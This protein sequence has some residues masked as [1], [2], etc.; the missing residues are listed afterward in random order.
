[1]S[2]GRVE[3]CVFYNLLYNDKQIS[4]KAY[5]VPYGIIYTMV[6]PWRTNCGFK[7]G[8]AD[9]NYICRLNLIAKVESK[10]KL[11]AKSDS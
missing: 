10:L 2:P 6:F 7:H 8:T 1:M 9:E 11:Q 4:Y 5:F 3:R